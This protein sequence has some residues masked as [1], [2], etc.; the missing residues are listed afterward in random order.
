MNEEGEFGKKEKVA[1][2][3]HFG[4]TNPDFLQLLLW[5]YLYYF[6]AWSQILGLSV[7]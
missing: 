3:R 2:Y 7:F 1:A 4:D 5:R 6:D